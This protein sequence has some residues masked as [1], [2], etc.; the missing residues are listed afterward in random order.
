MV[1]EVG[2][3][4]P[5]AWPADLQSTPL[6]S[7]HSPLRIKNYLSRRRYIW[8]TRRDR[9]RGASA[10]PATGT[11]VT[12]KPRD[13]LER[14]RFETSKA[15]LTSTRC[16]WPPPY[17]GSIAIYPTKCGSFVEVLGVASGLP[18]NTFMRSG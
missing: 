6:P 17:L 11:S 14:S 4:P 1:G 12:C 2:L 16:L 9:L 3:E 13:S 5:K 7:G 18:T 10:M 15:R 8:R